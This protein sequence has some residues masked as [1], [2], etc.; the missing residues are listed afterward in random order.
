MP[1]K[2]LFQMRKHVK[3]L[4]H[5]QLITA[6]HDSEDSMKY[7]LAAYTEAIKEYYDVYWGE[8]ERRRYEHEVKQEKYL[9]ELHKSTN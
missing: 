6:M 5:E 1:K 2:D 9:N 8:V 4:T 7:H 3:T